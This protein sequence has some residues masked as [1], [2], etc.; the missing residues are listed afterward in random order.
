MP[1]C[2]TAA[3][4]LAFF[5]PR[6]SPCRSYEVA[7]I[8]AITRVTNP[9]DAYSPSM[10]PAEVASVAEDGGAVIVENAGAPCPLRPLLPPS[11]LPIIHCAV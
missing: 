11:P 5:C 3:P 9:S 6:P 2:C 7:G 1:T 4:L 8:K 10:D